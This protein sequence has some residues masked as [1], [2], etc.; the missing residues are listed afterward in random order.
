[1]HDIERNGVCIEDGQPALARS[2]HRCVKLIEDKR[3]RF[4]VAGNLPFRVDLSNDSMIAVTGVCG[5]RR[6]SSDKVLSVVER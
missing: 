5:L 2:L 3:L 6:F 1:M 4:S